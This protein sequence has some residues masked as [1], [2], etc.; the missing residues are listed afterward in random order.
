MTF[1]DRAARAEQLLSAAEARGIAVCALGGVAVQ[2]LCPSARAGG[3]WHREL[4]DVDLATT[5]KSRRQT[6]ELITADGF[7]P[8]AEFNRM[9]GSVRLR[10]FDADGSHLDVFIDELR[11]CHAIEWRRSLKVGCATLPL[12]E[13]LLTK[14]QVVQQE[15]K[16]RSD[17]AALL[18]DQW[19]QLVQGLDRLGE[20]VRGDWG[21][22][23]TGQLSLTKLKEA[24][25]AGLV[26]ER[27]DELAERWQAFPLSAKARLRAS[28]GDRVRWYEEPEEV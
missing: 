6:E 10:Y 15:Q 25:P 11:L 18:T 2:L 26:H 28:I 23:H 22:W 13:L 17:L 5:T 27:A 24:S 14:L 16:D 21:L 9:N 3:S 12:P 19:E 1:P 7:E 8:D 4:A 20:L